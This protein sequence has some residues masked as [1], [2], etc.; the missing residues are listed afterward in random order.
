MSSPPDNASAP[1]QN[2]DGHYWR[3]IYSCLTDADETVFDE[4]RVFIDAP[5]TPKSFA[6]IAENLLEVLPIVG[7]CVDS[8]QDPQLSRNIPKWVG[9]CE[10]IVRRKDALASIIPEY[11]KTVDLP[12]KPPQLGAY[13]QHPLG[14]TLWCSVRENEYSSRYRL[15][16]ANLCL[17]HHYLR[18]LEETKEYRYENAKAVACRTT[19]QLSDPRYFQSLMLLPETPVKFDAYCRAVT[20][21]TDDP[22]VRLL[23]PLFEY[24]LHRKR[25][26]TH[27]RGENA[28]SVNPFEKAMQTI[29]FAEEDEDGR[30]EKI[31]IMQVQSGTLGQTAKQ[32]SYLC[33]PAE[34][35]D[36]RKTVLTE[37][38][39]NDPSGGFSAGQQY[40]KARAVT[41]AIA[42]H[43]QRLE[44]NWDSLTPHEV[45]TLLEG[46]EKL[47]MEEEV[48]SGIPSSELAAFLS[49]LFWTSATPEVAC[50]C[51]WVPQPAV[52]KTQLAIQ[53]EKSL[54]FW[55]VKPRSPEQRHISA[56]ILWEQALPLSSR[57]VLP[58]PAMAQRVLRQQLE[59]VSG[60][61]EAVKVFRRSS[62]AYVSASDAFL[63]KLRH[64]TGGRQTSQRLSKYLHDYLSRMPGSDITV[65]MAVSGREDVIGSVPL[66]YTAHSVHR[67]Q[68]LYSE[69]CS[70]ILDESG[71]ERRTFAGED[72]PIP[73]TQEVYVG[74]RYVPHRK[75][76]RKLIED[77]R[78]RMED[79]R[80]KFRAT[81]EGLLQLHNDLV[82]Y[83]VMM[84]GFATGYRAVRDPLL[85]DAEI[86]RMTGFAVISDKDDDRFRHSRIV[87]L[88]ELCIRQIDLFS[89]HSNQLQTL[90]FE[91]N[92]E[93]FFNVRREATTGRGRNRDNPSLFLLND[94]VNDLTVQPKNLNRLARKNDYRLPMNANRHYLRSNLLE[95]NC[96]VEIIN[97]FMG[98]ADRGREA[99][100]IY[101]GLSPHDYRQALADCLIPLLEEDG[102]R[103][104]SGLKATGKV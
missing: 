102:W 44:C 64:E 76:V 100:G 70:G 41:S 13:K 73:G 66:H 45:M 19:R 92:Q 4:L 60:N 54:R 75:T 40:L 101:S 89:E 2:R 98:H 33:S 42:M 55:V 61:M 1:S 80:E 74:S 86:D 82:V 69:A 31:I 6:V 94:A 14:V 103:A 78:A 12:S 79:A 30:S 72:I 49:I 87:W 88:P 67:V 37:H 56:S 96:P 15:L 5:L 59:K 95:R 21:N 20:E 22:M 32:K 90:L 39:G 63:R 99:W 77:L 11:S 7:L 28:Y 27:V 53:W 10:Q 104:E 51:E 3:S 18:H 81:Q 62:S 38:S 57:Y 46:I 17:A 29:D 43:N 58:I 85:Q 71:I 26:I 35:S 24:A 16:Q 84:L 65:A 91:E 93:L 25:G 47:A 68:E 52:S 50:R 23:K 36:A 48:F 8:A 34:F 9:Y 83:T 97:A